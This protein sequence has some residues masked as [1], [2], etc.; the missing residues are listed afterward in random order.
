MNNTFWYIGRLNINN[1][2]LT[3]VNPDECYRISTSS[4]NP[5]IC[6]GKSIIPL[7]KLKNWT[8]LHGE[9]TGPI[10]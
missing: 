3:G 2:D 10:D 6:E 5:L 7:I 4:N 1:R 9:I 8:N